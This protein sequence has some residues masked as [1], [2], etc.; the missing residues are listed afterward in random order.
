MANP[1]DQIATCIDPTVIETIPDA[2]EGSF[3]PTGVTNEGPDA[4]LYAAIVEEYGDGSVDTDPLRAGTIAGPLA[5]LINFVRFFDGYEGDVTAETAM[6]QMQ[7]ATAVPLF[8]SGGATATCDGTAIPILPNVCS[9]G[10]LMATL[11][12]NA[13]PTE[14]ATVDLTGLFTPPGG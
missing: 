3:L 11:D 14:V 1:K 10:V 9:T 2:Y 13:Q 8:L 4:D 7:T 6:T 5:H 12:A